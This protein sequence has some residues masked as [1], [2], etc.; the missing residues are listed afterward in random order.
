MSPKSFTIRGKDYY[1][2]CKY[3]RNGLPDQY[4]FIDKGVE[5]ITAGL[6][7]VLVTS[8]KLN[9]SKASIRKG[10]T[11]SLNIKKILPENATNKNVLWFTSDSKIATVSSTGKVKAIGK[12][13]CII[14]CMA[15]DGSGVATTCTIK[16]K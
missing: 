11:L 2:W 14:T 13:T 8:I 16:V 3:D 9:K 7:K 4:L 6:E 1:G 10:K 15:A 5:V 12:G